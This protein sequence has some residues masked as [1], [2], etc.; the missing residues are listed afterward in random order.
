VV[1]DGGVSSSNF[2]GVF[3]GWVLGLE[4]WIPLKEVVLICLAS[5]WGEIVVLILRGAYTDARGYVKKVKLVWR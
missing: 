1:K 4:V 2:F 3:K 5:R